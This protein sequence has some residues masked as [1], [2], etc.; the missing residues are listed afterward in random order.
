MVINEPLLL[1][2]KKRDNKH[3]TFN[4]PKKKKKHITFVMTRA[5]VPSPA[6]GRTMAQE[7]QN[8]EFV[9]EWVKTLGYS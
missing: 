3:V 2:P 9:E 7:A 8:N 5:W 4:L 1:S 6:R